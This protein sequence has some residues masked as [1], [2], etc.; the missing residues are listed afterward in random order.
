MTIDIGSIDGSVE[1]VQG[2]PGVQALDGGGYGNAGG[3]GL[4]NGGAG[5]SSGGVNAFGNDGVSALAAG[6]LALGNMSFTTGDALALAS[7]AGGVTAAALGSAGAGPVKATAAAVLTAGSI[8]AGSSAV[9]T[10]IGH[11]AHDFSTSFGAGLQASATLGMFQSIA[12]QAGVTLGGDISSGLISVY[13]GN[14]AWAEVDIQHGGSV[15]AAVDYYQM[16]LYNN[17][18]G[19]AGN[20]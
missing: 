1:A 20:A 11:L 2:G 13:A 17:V 9:Q 7:L 12:E 14:Y 6:P 8:I 15:T 10:A 18:S 3:G 4:D 16:A 19:Y 5:S